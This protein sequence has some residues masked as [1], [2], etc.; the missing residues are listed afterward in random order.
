MYEENA[1]SDSETVPSRLALDPVLR[2][3]ANGLVPLGPTSLAWVTSTVKPGLRTS[4]LLGRPESRTGPVL[5]E[6]HVSRHQ[7]VSG[8]TRRDLWWQWAEVATP[9]KATSGSVPEESVGSI[10]AQEHC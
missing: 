2:S 9:M 6:S 4:V 3:L 10:S 7:P 1:A 5:Y 8:A